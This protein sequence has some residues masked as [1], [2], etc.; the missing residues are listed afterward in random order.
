M[1]EVVE[2]IVEFIPEIVSD[3]NDVI[4]NS[5][6]MLCEILTNFV[7]NNSFSALYIF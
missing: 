1:K 4:P 6:F 3:W 5:N 2:E 7:L